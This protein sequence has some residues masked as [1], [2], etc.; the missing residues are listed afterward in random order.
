MSINFLQGNIT[1]N[2]VL[3]ARAFI[4]DNNFNKQDNNLVYYY[5]R[6]NGGHFVVRFKDAPNKEYKPKELLRIAY[7]IYK[8]KIWIENLCWRV[9]NF[10][11]A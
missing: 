8:G 6:A 4:D 1:L 3:Q 9:T 7:L 11:S 5:H 10:T 2:H